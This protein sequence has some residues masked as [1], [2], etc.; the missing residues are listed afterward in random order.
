M[1]PCP[2]IIIIFPIAI[3]IYEVIRSFDGFGV[4]VRVS[5]YVFG[6]LYGAEVC[7]CSRQTD[8][9]VQVQL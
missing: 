7:R 8:P 1:Y 9:L 2:I 3:Y 6:V 4:W 5:V